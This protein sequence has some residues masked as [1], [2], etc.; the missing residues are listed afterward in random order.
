[1][2]WC[3]VWRSK[4]NSIKIPTSFNHSTSYALKDWCSGDLICTASGDGSIQLWN[5]SDPTSTTPAMYYNEHSEEICSVDCCGNDIGRL[6]SSS[7]DCTIKLWDILYS[8]SLSTYSD[9][10]QLVYQSKF[11][12]NHRNTF[13][14]VSGDGC[15]KIWNTNCSAAMITVQTNSPE[16]FPLWIWS[17]KQKSIHFNFERF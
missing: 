4:L 6:I 11:S 10:S 15:L 12:P 8:K 14:S 1:M 3:F 5:S 2:G 17:Q 13:A 7:W 16:V 9:H